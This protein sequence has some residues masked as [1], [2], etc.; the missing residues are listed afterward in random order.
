MRSRPA[1]AFGGGPDELDGRAVDEE[2]VPEREEAPAAEP[3]LEHDVLLL[4]ADHRA[5][6]A[7]GREFDDE[8]AFGLDGRDRASAA[9]RASRRR[10][11][12][13]RSGRVRSGRGSQSAPHEASGSR[14]SGS[15]PTR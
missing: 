13:R 7:V 1:G 15:A 14:A 3:I 11:R 8:V 5:D 6:V 4:E 10:A 2:A 12:R 9:R